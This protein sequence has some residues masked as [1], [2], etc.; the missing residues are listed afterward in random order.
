MGAKGASRA[1][2]LDGAELPELKRI[3]QLV[4]HALD[5]LDLAV[6]TVNVNRR[7]A[8]P[9][10]DAELF[11]EHTKIRT[12]G[13]RELEQ[14]RWIGDLDVGGDVGF[15]G[16]ALRRSFDRQSLAPKLPPNQGV[17]IA[18]DRHFESLVGRENQS[19]SRVAIE[20]VRRK[21]CCDLQG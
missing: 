11:A 8:Q 9:H 15:S 19:P 1:G 12:P 21:T 18:L 5:E 6:R 17:R 14:E 20:R 3:D 7:A 10:G 2:H 4:K 13:A 16:A